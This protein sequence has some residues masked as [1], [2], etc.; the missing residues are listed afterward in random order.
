MI[1]LLSWKIPANIGGREF[2]EYDLSWLLPPD[3]TEGKDT[4]VVLPF[5]AP[6]QDDYLMYVPEDTGALYFRP[7][8]NLTNEIEYDPESNQYYFRNKIG[9][10][11]YRNPTFMSFD[12]YQ[13]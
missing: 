12:E 2:S 9:D 13:E 3:T 10:I 5:P 11:D 8:K 4:S 6:K 7:P 1:F